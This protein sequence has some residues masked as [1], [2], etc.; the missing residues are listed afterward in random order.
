[1]R[2]P[3]EFLANV[4]NQ[5]SS[6]FA[7]FAATE[8][9]QNRPE[10]AAGLGADPAALWK[11][12]LGERVEE[13]AT[14]VS[15]KKPQLFTTRVRWATASFIA[16]NVS[17]T[18]IEFALESLRHVLARELPAASQSLAD[19]YLSHGLT[20]IDAA[21]AIET[22]SLFADSK[23]GRLAASYLLTL[24]EGEPSKA[25][26]LMH[27]AVQ[28]GW[29]IA[30]LY[31]RVL[32]PAQQEVGRMWL[33]D[34]INVAEEHLATATTKMIMSQL[35]RGAQQRPRHGK[36]AVAAAVREDQHDVG[37]QMVTDLFEMHG[38]RTILLGANVP[39]PDLIQVTQTFEAD[40]LLL[41]AA[42][43]KQL[44]AMRDTIRAIRHHPATKDLKILVGGPA[45][46]GVT[47]LAE[48]FGADAYA[49]DAA[50]ALQTGNRLVGLP[51]DS[52]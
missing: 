9:L 5:G 39:T 8:M 44:V 41:S 31:T 26:S 14:A 50:E 49:A 22:E 23:E 35:R 20:A 38:W 29:G 47:D 37:L 52:A 17:A 15:A 48:K 27:K 3:N 45:F 36:T 18:N 40:L 21:A 2:Q 25:A 43:S 6:A 16:R 12:W 7:G 11:E 1:M 28:D 13:L 42:L 24:L 10:A 30:D 51:S 46:T 32:A 33:H 19:Q 34:E 4:L